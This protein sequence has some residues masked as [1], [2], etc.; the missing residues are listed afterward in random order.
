MSGDQHSC[1]GLSVG[2]GLGC[3]TSHGDG[4]W[5]GESI[6]VSLALIS[7][8]VIMAWLDKSSTKAPMFYQ[9]GNIAKDV[10]LGASYLF[11]DE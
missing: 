4:I 1:I 3:Q 7:Y 6:S 9:K 10:F 11:S 5:K 2:M 8:S